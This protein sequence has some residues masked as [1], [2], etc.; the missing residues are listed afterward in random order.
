MKRRRYYLTILQW[1]G[2]EMYQLPFETKP[3]R[4]KLWMTTAFAALLCNLPRTLSLHRSC[5]ST[6]RISRA[7]WS[8]SR[9]SVWT[10]VTV[11]SIECVVSLWSAAR[12][13]THRPELS[14][15]SQTKCSMSSPFTCVLCSFCSSCSRPTYAP[16]APGGPPCPALLP[17]S[18]LTS[19]GRCSSWRRES[20]LAG[21]PGATP[22][23]VTASCPSGPS[24]WCV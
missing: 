15:W 19:V 8:R 1:R 12:K 4:C 5:C 7:G 18:R 10:C 17:L 16:S 20:I 2:H 6:R 22:T 3:W 13:W 11:A 24:A 14:R 21:I 23:A 9:M